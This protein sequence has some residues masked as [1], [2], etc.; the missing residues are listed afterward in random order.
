MNLRFVT[1]IAIAIAVTLTA[2]GCADAEG[3][4]DSARLQVF[5]AASLTDVFPEMNDRPRYQF[6]GSDELAL[7]IREGAGADVFAAASPRYPLELNEDGLVEKP[8]V[9]ATNQ[10]VLIV[11]EDN[12]AD[13]TSV[14]D[15]R[16]PDVKF[17]IGAKGVPV[18]DY[19]R[20]VLEKLDASDLLDHVASEEQDVKGVVSKVRLG[21]ADAGFA[22]ATDVE[23]A[24]DEIMSIALPAK[25]QP[26]V[27]Y[28]VAVVADR[29]HL[30]AAE[31]FVELLLSGPGRAAL[32]QAGF[33]VP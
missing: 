21:E 18:G 20:Q 9:F 25:A 6:A 2:P 10:L 16:P 17:V 4:S 19:T 5:A 30:L 7:Q 28:M 32:E 3:G 23:A 1:T 27:E 29:P 13:I 14:D 12:P 26:T 31:E 24:Q 22:Y 8:V 11:P 15:L 33:G